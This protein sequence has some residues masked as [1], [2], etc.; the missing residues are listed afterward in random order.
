[1]PSRSRVEVKICCFHANPWKI[2]LVFCFEA[3]AALQNNS[4][5][6]ISLKA[7]QPSQQAMVVPFSVAYSLRTLGSESLGKCY[8]SWEQSRIPFQGIFQSTSARQ[9]NLFNAHSSPRR[10]K[11]R[12]VVK[13]T[14]ELKKLCIKN[15]GDFITERIRFIYVNWGRKKFALFLVTSEHNYLPLVKARARVSLGKFSCLVNVVQEE[16]QHPPLFD[17]KQ[18][19]TTS[20]SAGAPYS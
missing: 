19:S 12:S 4:S 13:V 9:V 20:F 7:L 10:A 8:S 17:V 16:P 18:F 14:K 5:S 11:R 15:C 1:M 3:R 6:K 2:F